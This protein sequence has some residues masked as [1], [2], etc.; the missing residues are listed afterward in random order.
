MIQNI[1]LI[2]KLVPIKSVIANANNNITLNSAKQ[3]TEM[4]LIE[5]AKAR[6]AKCDRCW[7]YKTD[8]GLNGKY[9][10]VC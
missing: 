1:D 10:E 3:A 5:V 8:I 2:D 6:G 4:G 9:P 7:H